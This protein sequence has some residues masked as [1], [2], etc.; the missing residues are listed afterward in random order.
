M[1]VESI[2]EKGSGVINE[3][4]CILNGSQFGVFDGATSLSSA[5]YENGATGGFLASNIA[6]EVFMNSDEPLVQLAERAN[7][8]I[9]TA[10]HERGVDL[11]DKKYLWSTSAAVVRVQDDVFEWVQ[12]G[13]CLVLVLY[14]DGSHEIVCEKHDHDFETLKM[15]Q[16]MA[17]DVDEPICE[18]LRDQ[19]LKVRSEM[20]VKYGVLSGEGDAMSFLSYGRKSLENVRNI[21]IFT[22]GLFIPNSSLESRDDFSLFADLFLKGG[23]SCVRDYIRQMEEEDIA[24]KKYPRFKPHDDIAAISI[25]L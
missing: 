8:A 12:I 16:C 20:N 17:G 23:L 6:G 1:K 22:D 3:D 11:E 25:S 15:W 13:D 21:L 18:A 9:G 14:E 19:I 24:C 7:C 4:Y 2:F 10:M 5:T